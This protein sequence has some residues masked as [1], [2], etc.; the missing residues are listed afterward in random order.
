MD[1]IR[2]KVR[3]C[4]YDMTAHVMEEMAEDDLDILDGEQA[5]LNAQILTNRSH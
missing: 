4:Q 5:V 1:S 2:E 3:R